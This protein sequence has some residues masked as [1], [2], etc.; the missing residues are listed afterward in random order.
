MWRTVPSMTAFTVWML[1]RN[2]RELTLWAWLTWRPKVGPL[3]Q[4][5]HDF[6]MMLQGRGGTDG[7]LDGSVA[8]PPE[9]SEDVVRS[10]ARLAGRRVSHGTGRL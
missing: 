1:G 5:S 8:G 7:E 6:A 4:I 2:R 10:V 9:G 3:P